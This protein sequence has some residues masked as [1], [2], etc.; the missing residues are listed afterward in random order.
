MFVGRHHVQWHCPGC[1]EQTARWSTVP[2]HPAD[3]RLSALS[4]IA[5]CA[6]VA[7]SDGVLRCYT[8]GRIDSSVGGP[9]TCV[10]APPQPLPPAP[11]GVLAGA[12]EA[13]AAGAAA[14]GEASAEDRAAETALP[15]ESDF[16]VCWRRTGKAGLPGTYQGCVVQVQPLLYSTLLFGPFHWTCLHPCTPSAGGTGGRRGS[17]PVPCSRTCSLSIS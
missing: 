10:V 9:A 7:T 17:N 12:G 15:D 1:F 8:F 14:G 5:H 2:E 16:E 3:H 11:P 4:D 6:Q 13:A